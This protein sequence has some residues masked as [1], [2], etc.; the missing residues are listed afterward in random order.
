MEDNTIHNSDPSP[1][2][3]VCYKCG[4]PDVNIG[5]STPLCSSCREKATK[6]PFP[7]W[8]G[9]LICG[10]AA[11]SWL[12]LTSFSDQIAT[13]IRFRKVTEAEKKRDY[14]TA[15]KE[16]SEILERDSTS[17]EAAG[18]LL[19]AAFYNLDLKTFYST[20][21]LLQGKVI[22]D[23]QMYRRLDKL[24]Y[25]IR[26]YTPSENFHAFSNTYEGRPIPDSLFQQFLRMNPEDVFAMTS[27]SQQL[28]HQERYR[29]S[30]S[31]VSQVMKIDAGNIRA[32]LIKANTKR[33]LA[34]YD[35][36]LHFCRVVLN[37]NRQLPNAL[38]VKART[39]LQMG[40]KDEALVSA[41]S[42][43]A[44]DPDDPYTGATLALAL[45]YT[46]KVHERDSLVTHFS[47]DS[48]GT[49]YM[50]YVEDVIQGKEKFIQ[51]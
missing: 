8:G 42:A 36:A 31:V 23:K 10:L 2:M 19:I 40:K 14:L 33:L 41:R 7:L 17:Q 22:R 27:Y 48:T 29:E 32:L 28:Q 45:H 44:A 13:G 49:A 34:Q 9:L 25:N 16:L 12:S 39:L 43:V 38:A 24:L 20:A 18:R 15:Q 11:M 30:D 37:I 26:F 47:E 46:G 21:S 1:L 51:E 5:Y 6:Y 4:S 50:K 35:S 3:N